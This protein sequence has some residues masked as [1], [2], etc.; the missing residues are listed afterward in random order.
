MF[1]TVKDKLKTILQTLE[2]TGKPL[3][4]VFGYIEPTPQL[5]PCAMIRVSGTSTESRLDSGSNELMMEFTI[6]VLLRVD[7]SETAENQRLDLLD[8]IMDAFRTSA[9]VDTL[10][11]TVDKFDVHS[12]IQIETS[13]DQPAFGFDLIVQA[14]KM[15]LIS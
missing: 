10:A 9:N 15:M 7:N 4:E 12:M 5:Y 2:G 6:R 1:K 11:G 3:K 13:E 14:S 8:S